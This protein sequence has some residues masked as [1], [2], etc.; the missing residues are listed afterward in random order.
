MSAARRRPRHRAAR[1]QSQLPLLVL[2][3]LLDGL[4]VDVG[5]VGRRSFRVERMLELGELALGRVHLEDRRFP[6][7]RDGVRANHCGGCGLLLFAGGLAR[8]DLGLRL[9]VD[10]AKLRVAGGNRL[11]QRIVRTDDGALERL[12]DVLLDLGNLAA[13]VLVGEGD[14]DAGR[15]SAA[16]AADAVDVVLGFVGEV[17]VDDVLK[18]LHVDAAA[19][20]V[21]RDHDLDLAVA[22][23]VEHLEALVLVHVAGEHLDGDTAHAE[24]VVDVLGRRLAVAEDDRPR[25]RMERNVVEE[26]GELVLRL[27]DVDDLLHRVGRVSL[28]LDLGLVG[29]LHPVHRETHN[30]VVQRRGVE[31]RRALL[32]RRQVAHY[33]PDVGDEAHVKHA[34][35][36]VDDERV[37]VRKVDDARLHEVEETARSR[38]EEVD[39]SRLDLVALAVVVH[40][41]VNRERPEPGV[42]A[43]R[44]GV[45]ADLYDE[46]ARRRDDES[47]RSAALFRA[48]LGRAEIAREDRNEERGCLSGTSLRLAGDVLPGE[49]LFKRERLNLGAV[50]E[51]EV[52]DAVHHLGRKVEIVETLLALDGLDGEARGIPFRVGFLARL[53][54]L[55]GN[56]AAR[57]HLVCGGVHGSGTA[58][59]AIAA[60]RGLATVAPLLLAVL[61]LALLLALLLTLLRLLLLAV[62]LPLLLAAVLLLLAVAALAASASAAAAF[63]LRA[64]LRLGRLLAGQRLRDFLQKSKCHV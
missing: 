13:L 61:L 1:R 49:R 7:A 41:A 3:L 9:G 21:G 51:T 2:F 33:A 63:L 30:G 40:S 19:C 57:T 62:L 37:D 45:L 25:L 23:R 32:L 4:R 35:G 46:L 58:T 64:I 10:F 15:A 18:P 36:L 5:L 8:V 55:G 31:H 39:G 24:R 11:H 50:L 29:S 34:V 14:R 47:A 54:L 28:G 53:Q 56:L 44:V 38:D 42:L 26:D 6:V 59:P 27:D 16:R 17:E 12:V 52:G 48:V 22:E 60:T 43:D 20:D